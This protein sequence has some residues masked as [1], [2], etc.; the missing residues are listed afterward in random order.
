MK[1]YWSLLVIFSVSFLLSG[2]I[3][4]SYSQLITAPDAVGELVA[5]PGN[6]E[7]L[8]TWVAPFDGG[9]TI[10]SYKVEMWQTGKDVITTYSNLGTEIT[11]ARITGLTNGVSY[12]FKVFAVNAKGQSPDSNIVTATPKGSP[13]TFAP[14]KI[15][16]LS[17]TR[18]NT[19]VD[20]KWT[21]PF[22]FGDK[23]TS[24][25]IYYW[26]VGTDE[27]KTKTVGGDSK[28][29]QITG[30]TNETPYS[31]KVIAKNSF[32][33]GP[34]S[35]IVSETPSTSTVATVPNKVR[36]VNAIPSNNQVY[37]TWI[38]PSSNGSPITNYQVKVS[39]AG[40]NVVTTFPNIGE[41]ES[42]TIT[43]LKNGVKYN[44][45]VIAINSVGMSKPSDVVSATPSNRV[46]IEITNLKATRG[47]GSVTLTWT[48][49]ESAIN[50]ISGYWVR[51]YKTGD[52]SFTTH[53]I[54][55]KTTKTRITGLDN[56]VSY[57]FSIIAVTDAGIGPNSKI[58]NV[59]PFK[60]VTYPG[61]P[62]QITDLKATAGE[63]QVTLSWTK[64]N[65]FGSPI[66]GYEIQKS[67][68][69]E[70]I[71]ETISHGT[72]TS[73]TLKG[74]TNGVT[75]DF[76]VIPINANGSGPE[77]NSVSA[78]PKMKEG[79]ISIP[80][81]IKTNAKWWSEDKISDLEYVRAIEYLINNGIIRLK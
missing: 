81:W 1:K 49:P 18:G 3:L 6:G 45:Q 29:A 38:Q 59:T 17:A 26:K 80:S 11:E 16:D 43:G 72:S 76:K 30:L 36:G 71:F 56:G 21:P 41:D 5:L 31:F 20:L 19:K 32:G 61:T 8:L 27:I 68:R 64:P 70:S 9:S 7:I 62:S 14:E 47:D 51:E 15:T 75:Y 69:G 22:D 13:T 65:D 78:V 54:L 66:V 46:S 44:F 12:S 58:V 67:I 73:V 40:S 28:T 63:N 2:L 60:P 25:K 42:T 48:V 33:H 23:I 39:E 52:T 55:D 53:V 79:G 4:S 50:Q 74:L 34:D 77:S 35:N 24:Y 37:L 57:G 10:K